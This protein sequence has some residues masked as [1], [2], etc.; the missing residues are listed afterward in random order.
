MLTL[1]LP[2]LRFQ[3][4]A[5]FYLGLYPEGPLGSE[6]T[7]SWPRQIKT[8]LPLLRLFSHSPDPQGLSYDQGLVDSVLCI[9][10]YYTSSPPAYFLTAGIVRLADVY[11]SILI[12][13]HS[14]VTLDSPFIIYLSFYWYYDCGKHIYELFS[15]S[16]FSFFVVIRR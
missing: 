4:L 8:L 12:V 11:I 15:V 10:L 13:T 14:K 6:K 3:V 1:L 16:C 5:V 7:T 9:I 2:T